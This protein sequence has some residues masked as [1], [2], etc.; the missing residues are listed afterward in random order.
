MSLKSQLFND[1]LVEA[2]QRVFAQWGR[3]GYKLKAYTHNLSLGVIPLNA[4]AP[5]YTMCVA[6][7]ME[8]IVEA[9]QQYMNDTGD[10]TPELYLQPRHWQSNYPSGSFRDLM[11]VNSGSR[12]TADA[13]ATYGMGEVCKFEELTSGGFVNFNRSGG[14]GHATLF[15]SYLDADGRSLTSYSDAVAGFRYISSQGTAINGGIDYASAF[16]EGRCPTAPIAGRKDCRVMRAEKWLN[17]GH[18]YLP[19]F[20]NRDRATSGIQTQTLSQRDEHLVDERANPA[21]ANQTLF[22]VDE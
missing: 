1:Y 19:S 10:R 17:C 12:G 14:S 4:D 15:L 5:P 7:V 2:S 18:M 6:A 8:F 13:L 21:Y 22:D 11:W 16:F 20:W 9:L 3:R